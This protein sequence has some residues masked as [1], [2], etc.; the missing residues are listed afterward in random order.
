MEPLEKLEKDLGARHRMQGAALDHDGL[1]NL[2]KRRV[3][4]SA[5]SGEQTTRAVEEEKDL[6]AL[7]DLHHMRLT[8]QTLTAGILSDVNTDEEF[9]F[10][11]ASLGSSSQMPVV[12]HVALI[13]QF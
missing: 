3:R 10:I 1:L 2:L 5:Q 11:A 13:S 12:S 9:P 6:A 4:E 8:K 7:D